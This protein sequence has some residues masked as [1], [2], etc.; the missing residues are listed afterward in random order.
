MYVYNRIANPQ[1]QHPRSSCT[2]RVAVVLLEK[3]VPFE[4]VPVVGPASKT[5]EYKANMQPFGQ[6]PVLEDD[7]YF[8]YGSYVPA[9]LIER[10]WCECYGFLILFFPP[11]ES[12][13]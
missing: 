3:G 12:R 5:P 7:G 4:L 13:A 6:I 11:A 9:L 8:L 1:I 2:K 10:C